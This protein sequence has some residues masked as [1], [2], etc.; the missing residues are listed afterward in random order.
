[1]GQALEPCQQYSPSRSV[2]RWLRGCQQDWPY[3]FPPALS[4]HQCSKPEILL[5]EKKKTKQKNQ[6]LQREMSVLIDLV[7]SVSYRH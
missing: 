4:V 2:T 1:M 7:S 6:Q 5:G 3:L